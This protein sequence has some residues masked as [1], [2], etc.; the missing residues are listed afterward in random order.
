M[1]R[2]TSGLFA[3]IGEWLNDAPRDEQNGSG[4]RFACL[5]L[6]LVP[7]QVAQ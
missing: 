5:S 7:G 1:A 4:H 3:E 6:D 2:L